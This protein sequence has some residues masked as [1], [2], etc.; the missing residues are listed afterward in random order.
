MRAPFSGHEKKKVKIFP[1]DHEFNT[2][3]T[4]VSTACLN[5]QDAK[6]QALVESIVSQTKPAAVH[7]GLLCG[8]CSRVRDKPLPQHLRAQ[9]HDPPPL[10]DANNLLGFPTLVG[11]LRKFRLTTTSRVR[12]STYALGPCSSGDA[13]KACKNT[14]AN[15]TQIK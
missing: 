5:L 8:T 14:Q 6:S 11:T 10:R 15:Q 7:L 9:F 1:V 3:K 12:A 4:A 13:D 2:H